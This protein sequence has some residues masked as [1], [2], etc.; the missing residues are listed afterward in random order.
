M[1]V[2]MH[3]ISFVCRLLRRASVIRETKDAV[4]YFKVLIPIYAS[5]VTIT[6]KLL[7]HW[8]WFNHIQVKTLVYNKFTKHTTMS[9]Y[10]HKNPLPLRN[11]TAHL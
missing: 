2:G 3:S 1:Y 11:I 4:V 8:K 7:E 9:A 6:T 10:M 5:V